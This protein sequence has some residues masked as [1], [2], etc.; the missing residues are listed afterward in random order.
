MKEII[1]S[2]DGGSIVYSVPVRNLGWTGLGD[3]LPEEYRDLS[4][5]NF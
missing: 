2:A 5:Y 3:E 4:Y 1:L